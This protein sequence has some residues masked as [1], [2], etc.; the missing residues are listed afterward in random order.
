MNLPHPEDFIDIHTHGGKSIDAVYIIE[1]LM[2]HEEITPGNIPE[3]ACSFGIH[4][5]YL[6][7]ENLDHL[8]SRVKA[9]TGFPN[10]LAIGEAGF[11]KLR[12]PSMELQRTAF[13]QQIVISE[14]IGKPVVIHC[15]RAWGELLETFKK[16]KPTMPWL[17]H[18]FRGNLELANQLLSKGM[19]LS[20]WF[21][22][23]IKPESANLLRNLSRNR[24]FL[25]TDGADIDIRDIYNKVAKDLNMSVD[26]L[27]L[28]ILGNFKTLF[29]L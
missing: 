13:E 17:I 16:L 3:H 26:E 29:G 8:L 18:G 14:K 23:A 2:A 24:I 27:K 5:W 4:P 1:N 10:V 11:D 12:G 19:Y 25:E 21:D 7:E 6:N 28:L 15:V 9:V 20:F 22:Y